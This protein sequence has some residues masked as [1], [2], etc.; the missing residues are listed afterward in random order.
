MRSWRAFVFATVTATPTFGQAPGI[1][2]IIYHNSFPSLLFMLVD[3]LL[4]ESINKEINTT[5]LGTILTAVTAAAAMFAAFMDTVVI[6]VAVASVMD[7]MKGC[8]MPVNTQRS[9]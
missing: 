8:M 4:N 1:M 3:R 9:L 2:V 7:A 5:A 6:A